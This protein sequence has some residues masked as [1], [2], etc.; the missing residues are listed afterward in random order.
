MRKLGLAIFYSLRV[1]MISIVLK[2]DL[3]KFMFLSKFE[4]KYLK[5]VKTRKFSKLK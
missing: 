2:V 3:S 5:V 1:T 4:L